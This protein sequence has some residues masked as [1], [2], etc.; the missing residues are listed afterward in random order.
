[1]PDMFAPP[2]TPARDAVHSVKSLVTA[3][4]DAVE[5]QFR[6]VWVEGEITNLGEPRS[7]H[8][9]FSLVDD[10][11]AIR[12]VLF[13]NRLFQSACRPGDGMRVLLRAK[14]SVYGARGDL[15]LIVEHL[16][17]AG[18]GALRRE[19]E[20]LKRQ[21]G[22]EGLFSDARKKPL[23]AYPR[24]IGVITS[25]SGAA[26]HDI[27]VT[28]ARRFPLARLVIYPASVQ[29]ARAVEDVVAML[30]VADRRRDA[31]VLI[32]ARGGG[33]LEDLQAFNSEAV[34]RAIAA[35]GL[36]VVSAIGHETD[37][38]IADMVADRRAPTPTAAAEIVAPDM[39]RLRADASRLAARLCD[40]AQRALDDAR[41]RLDYTAARLTHPRDRLRLAAEH[42]RALAGALL[43]CIRQSLARRGQLIE[44]QT[45]ALRYCS[46]Q[47]TLAA[48]RARLTDAR[49]RLT[50][51]TGAR[52]A[53]A[54]ARVERATVA[55]RA[56]SP[57]HTLQRGYAILTDRDGGGDGGG[58]TQHNA[59]RRTVITDARQ[60]R[61]GQTLTARVARGQF[62]CVVDRPVEE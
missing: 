2:S 36:P 48:N 25:K 12:C 44:R 34:A 39:A 51:A 32:V 8:K 31:Q 37:F 45:T 22:A 21:L 59:D 28:L 40:A 10:A 57:L 33:S 16:E 6:A 20:R 30:A 35:C 62:I 24:S 14:A 58:N 61:R 1:M 7:G 29:G 9:Y 49:A 38:T 17:A 15:Q 5:D 18:E 11:A 23:P 19:F 13:K 54:R 3:L 26:L 4:R 27:R 41:L 52:L 43:H 53:D 55:T 42:R 50:A 47:V 46:P 56:L 60:T